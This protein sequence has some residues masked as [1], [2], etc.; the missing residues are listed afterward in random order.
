MRNIARWRATGAAAWLLVVAGCG[1]GGGGGEVIP[2]PGPAL[3]ATI[4]IDKPAA[5]DMEAAVG[6][7]SSV[8]GLAGVRH[9]WQFGDGDTSTEA[10]PKHQYR[11]AGDYIVKLTVSNGSDPGREATLAVSVS[12][13]AHLAGRL[14]SGA[15]RGGWCRMA[16][17]PYDVPLDQVSYASATL[18]WALSSGRLF[19]TTD[20]GKSWKA[21]PLDAAGA[22]HSVRIRADG[23]LILALATDG[24]VWRSRDGGASFVAAG[25]V[26]LPLGSGLLQQAG[27]AYALR[28]PDG[29][30]WVSVDDGDTWQQS[31]VDVHLIDSDG[32]AWGVDAGGAVWAST[33]LGRSRQSV[34][35]LPVEC[36]GT[37]VADPARMSGVAAAR[38]ASVAWDVISTRPGPAGLGIVETARAVIC[39]SENGGAQW[40]R[41][42]GEGLWTRSV[43]LYHEAAPVLQVQ[44]VEGGWLATLLPSWPGEFSAGGE[45]RQLQAGAAAWLDPTGWPDV[46]MKELVSGNRG[47][48][49]LLGQGPYGES[50]WVSED[51]GRSWRALPLAGGAAAGAQSWS[52]L[53]RLGFLSLDGTLGELGWSRVREDGNR[54]MIARSPYA[55][56]IAAAVSPAPGRLLAFDGRQVLRSEDR[57][58][59]WSARL[60]VNHGLAS[61]LQFAS[62]TTGWL[63][64]DTNLLLATVDGGNS[65][66]A[67]H[68]FAN[69]SVSA[70]QFQSETSGSAALWAPDGT[71]ALWDTR[72]GGASWSMRSALPSDLQSGSMRFMPSGDLLFVVGDYGGTGLG[73]I[74]LLKAGRSSPE[75]VL[76]DG[77]PGVRLL[78]LSPQTGGIWWAS[79][80]VGRLYRSSDGGQTWQRRDTGVAT[81]LHAVAFA[82]E[83]HGWVVG[84]E[85]TVLATHDGG[86]SWKVQVNGSRARLRTLLVEDAKT[87]WLF[88]DGILATGTG[89]D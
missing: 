89:G 48:W 31:L 54:L 13:K 17:L 33:D 70:I 59:T 27:S 50:S 47:A 19:V 35:V 74:Y 72:D 86:Q 80:E 9:Q 8:A 60:T 5:T 23:Q 1:G 66:T 3:P 34:G 85:G 82:D 12:N 67:R 65:W 52:E 7:S 21:Q 10:S 78:A 29:N 16:P 69:A 37:A 51:Q 6:F 56:G 2:P 63:V 32:K 75:R 55:G 46:R 45:R 44:P 81:D 71:L 20:A 11:V 15:D 22:L 40:Q 25:R 83:R 77:G 38:L 36:R 73:G 68:L 84:S 39:T 79:G 49:L 28:A 30:R 88:G 62:A 24:K 58:R 42:P 64:A 57:G 43:W 18:G 76:P 53:A 61:S 4:S 87:V 14:C 41:Q 26:P